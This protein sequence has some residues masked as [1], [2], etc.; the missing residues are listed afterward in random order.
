MYGV[1][2]SLSDNLEEDEVVFAIKVES[3]QTIAENMG[4]EP[5]NYSE[6]DS[7]RKGIEWGLDFW[8]DIVMTAINNLPSEYED[9]DENE[10]A[11]SEY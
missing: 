3:V 6:M 8:S 5:L 2:K 9:I 1:Y 10:V 4:R 11:N 7:V